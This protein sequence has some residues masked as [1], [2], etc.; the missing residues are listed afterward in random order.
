[1]VS[2]ER[3]GGRGVLFLFFIPAA[4]QGKAPPPTFF[5]LRLWDGC[6]NETHVWLVERPKSD[7]IRATLRDVAAAC[8]NECFSRQ[9]VA[10]ESLRS[11]S[12]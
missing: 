4:W 5:Y 8:L 1:M 9:T 10:T 7:E 2:L 3:V 12:L 11:W 6:D